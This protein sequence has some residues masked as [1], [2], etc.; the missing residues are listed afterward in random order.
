[1]LLSRLLAK[2]KVLPLL[3]GP[4]VCGRSNLPTQALLDVS[5][6][7]VRTIAPSMTSMFSSSP[8]FS[9]WLSIKAGGKSMI[10]S[11]LPS[12]GS[13][14]IAVQRFVSFIAVS[15]AKISDCEPFSLDPFKQV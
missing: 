9:P 14:H 5:D 12:A 2:Y 3:E 8:V 13:W 11:P 10:M 4:A 1:M 6:I 15:Y 7:F